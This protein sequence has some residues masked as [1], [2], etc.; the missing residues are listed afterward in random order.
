MNIV[1]GLDRIFLVLA[2]ISVTAWLIILINIVINSSRELSPENA[3]YMGLSLVVLFFSVLYGLKWLL[4]FSIWLKKWIV[5]G[6][7]DD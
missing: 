3:I 2:I 5:K 1:K 6:F 7:Y 4:R